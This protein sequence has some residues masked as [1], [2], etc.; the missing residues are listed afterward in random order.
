[1][2]GIVVALPWEL[3][4]LTRQAVPAGTCTAIGDNLLVAHS[5]IG[6][7]RAYAAG[8][9]LVSQGATALLSWGYAAAIDDRLTAGSVLLP[10]RII[11]MTGESH[12]VSS[13]WHRRL[14]QTLSAKYPVGTDPLVESA[15]VVK[16]PSEKQA[17]AHRTQATA[18]D[19]ES[20]AQARLARERRLPFA[21]VRAVVDTASTCIPQNLMQSFEPK[22]DIRV[23]QV[24][25]NALLRPTDWIAMIK[26]SMQ[27]NAARRTLKKIRGPVLDA[28]QFYLDC[29]SL[30]A[31][32]P[33][34]A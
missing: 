2:L 7:E 33:S 3:K 32:T 26:L 10:R 30:N 15:V 27:F 18:T 17:L 20:A 1:M 5:G 21:V 9:L 23:G 25:G 8:V 19:M 11:G 31:S 28:S 34:R 6:S 13:E 12:A 14:Y 24:L 16:T 29:I 22:D 4:S